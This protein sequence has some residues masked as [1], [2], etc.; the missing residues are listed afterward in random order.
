MTDI[1]QDL[2]LPV[3]RPPPR[4]HGIVGW[5]RANLFSS[6]FNTVLTVLALFFLA[7]TIPGVIRW[8]LLDAIWSAPNGQSCRGAGGEKD[9]EWQAEDQRQ[10]GPSAAELP[11]GARLAGPR[12]AGDRP[13]GE[14]A[15]K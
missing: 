3:E 1:A 9:R 15:D 2:P 5:L 10:P 4:T 12:P 11:A 13:R 6:V 14:D 8:A 7:V